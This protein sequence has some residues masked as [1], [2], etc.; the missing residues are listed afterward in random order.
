[1]G[2]KKKKRE[3]I[4]KILQTCTYHVR[5]WKRIEINMRDFE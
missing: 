1:M 5:M 3:K 2:V 4:D